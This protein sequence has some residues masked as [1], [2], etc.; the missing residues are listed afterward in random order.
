MKKIITILSALFMSSTIFAGTKGTVATKIT[1]NVI[2][3]K[4]MQTQTISVPATFSLLAQEG[5]SQ[6]ASVGELSV[7][8]K[9]QGGDGGESGDVTLE[10]K[11][12]DQF[13][14]KVL[15]QHSDT[16]AHKGG[17][18]GLVYVSQNPDSFG[19]AELQYNCKAE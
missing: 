4:D 8:L 6:S 15:W 16:M 3:G 1:C 7:T 12:N 14:T 9:S 11:R 2:S 19:G 5:G 17:T 10:V 18:T 13:L